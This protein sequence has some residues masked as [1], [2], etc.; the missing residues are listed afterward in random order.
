MWLTSQLFEDAFA[1]AEAAA[2]QVRPQYGW[3]LDPSTNL[4][5]T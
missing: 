3:V 5:F 1:A 4:G 2:A